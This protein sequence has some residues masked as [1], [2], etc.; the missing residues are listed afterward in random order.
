MDST[1]HMAHV[2]CYALRS[3]LLQMCPL[4]PGLNAPLAKPPLLLEARQ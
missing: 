2:Y 4:A 1:W 3:K